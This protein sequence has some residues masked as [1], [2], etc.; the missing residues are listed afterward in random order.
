MAERRM[1]AKAIVT[2]DAYLDMPATARLL[3]YDLGMR[4]DD[5]GFVNSP[6]RVMRETGASEDDLTVLKAKG[7]VI[8]F[9]SGIYVIKHWRINNQL[10]SDRHKAT[11]Y[12]EEFAMLEIKKN[13]SYSLKK[14]EETAIAKHPVC[15]E[16]GG[17][18]RYA[19]G[20]LSCTDCGS[21]RYVLV[22]AR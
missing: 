3:Y 20:A 14:P 19:G 7:F 13:K 1:F 11:E 12:Q 4:A 21:E 8:G 16:C 18:M 22:E 6:R 10:K 5:D 2:S 15:E 9:D 17:A